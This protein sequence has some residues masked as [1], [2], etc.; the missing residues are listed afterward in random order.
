MPNAQVVLD[1][2]GPALER[3]GKADQ[4]ELRDAFTANPCRGICFACGFIRPLARAH[5][6]ARVEGGSDDASN[7]HLLC[8]R[9]HT[10]SE[11]L[12]GDRYWRWFQTHDQWAEIL[13]MGITARPDLASALFRP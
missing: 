6:T 8:R 10:T 1:Y 3:M 11:Y 7:L 2:W 12:S 9:C 13:L 4:E 5:I